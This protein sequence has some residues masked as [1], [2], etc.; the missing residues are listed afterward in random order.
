MTGPEHFTA[1]AAEVLY[2]LN[3]WG[4]GFLGAGGNGHLHVYPGRDRDL[5]IDVPAVIEVLAARG[6]STPVLLR[7]PQLLAAQVQTL[8]RAFDRA[9]A[10]FEYPAGFHP[11]FPIKV[12][13]R[14]PV[15]EALLAAGRDEALGLEVGSL[16]ELLAAMAL[17]VPENALT[18][19]N[20]YK[21]AG[22]LDAAAMTARMG[23]QVVVVLEKPFEVDQYLALAERQEIM[24]KAGIR[25]RLQARGSGLWE[26][27]GGVASKFGLGT[28]QL[29]EAIDRLRDAGQ[30]HNLTLLHFHIGSQVTEIRRIKKAVREAARIYAKVVSLGVGLEYLDVGGGLGVDY[31]GSR[32]S[33][34]ASMNYSAQ[35]Y[36]NDVV[37]TVKEVCDHEEVAPPRL[38]SES[39]RMLAAYHSMLVT[40][41]RATVKGFG[42]EGRFEQV[43]EAEPAE[44]GESQELLDLQAAA[45]DITVKNYREFYH[46]AL[47]Y[48]ERLGNAFEL[49]LLTLKQRA[50]GEEIF[51]TVVRRAVRFSRAA[52]FRAEEFVDLEKKLHEKYVCNFSVFQSLPDH[53]ALDQLFPV[54]PI[55]RLDE[56]PTQRASLA[57]ITC[58]SEGEVEKFVDL[59]DE[60]E[61][62]EVHAL[63][64][65]E[66]YRIAFLM[67]GAYQDTM[68]DLHNLFGRVHEVDVRLDENGTTTLGEVREGESAGDTLAAFGFTGDVLMNGVKLALGRQVENGALKKQDA[69]ELQADYLKRLGG[70]TY[71]D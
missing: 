23:R 61:A 40:D 43:E 47:E 45:T 62:L 50:R 31:D 10:E 28:A 59:R 52:K 6:L 57:D 54:V 63:R 12:N 70:Y 3:S 19:C 41:V 51:W 64:E 58:D 34:D 37:Y 25:I 8:T 56:R 55:Q 48:R 13:Q 29:L 49:G 46:D 69:E 33:S 53:Y 42:G 21:D 35:E 26:K 38:I 30:D 16:P 67:L 20:G 2:G 27:S 9:I 24:P 65:G 60:K 18:I 15:V 5:F 11:V 66:P 39:G 14:R 7:F 68:G 22:Y 71:L 4:N 44:D 32:T 36:A 17:P 1:E